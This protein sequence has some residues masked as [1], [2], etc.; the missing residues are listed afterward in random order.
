MEAS[1]GSL[2]VCAIGVTEKKSGVSV[3]GASVGGR[4]PRGA[5]ETSIPTIPTETPA[6][7]TMA[8][9]DRARIRSLFIVHFSMLIL[10][11]GTSIIFTGVW[12]YL[13]MVRRRQ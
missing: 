7:D 13:N 2:I 11:L 6:T 4:A 9:N 10:S 1:A 12:P 3:V 8:T 5:S